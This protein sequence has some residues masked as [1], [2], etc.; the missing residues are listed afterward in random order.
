MAHS[1]L[2][3]SDLAWHESGPEGWLYLSHL[4]ALVAV[5]LLVSWQRAKASWWPKKEALSSEGEEK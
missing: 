5:G 3:L 4:H 1:T 2:R